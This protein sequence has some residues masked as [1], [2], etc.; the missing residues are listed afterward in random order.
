[1][2]SLSA[3][4]RGLRFLERL[5]D[6]QEHLV[7]Q[8]GEELPHLHRLFGREVV[9]LGQ[10]HR[11]VVQPLAEERERLDGVAEAEMITD[12][13][14]AVLVTDLARFIDEV[15]AAGSLGHILGDEGDEAAAEGAQALPIAF[16]DAGVP[17]GLAAA[18]LK[19]AADAGE[20]K[21][22]Q[23]S[24]RFA[25]GGAASRHKAAEVFFGET[26]VA[27]RGAEGA[28]VPGVGPA[29]ERGLVYAEQLAGLAQGDPAGRE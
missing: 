15:G 23:R 6:G 29:P 24:V 21:L 14:A 27:A 7:R 11:G 22:S 18:A 25:R 5:R 28:D 20:G 4:G 26:A 3:Y 2:R 10:L 16:S 17:G 13:L 12:E 1:M 9:L 8:V 19:A